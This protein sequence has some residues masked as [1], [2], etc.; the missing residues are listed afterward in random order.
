MTHSLSVKTEEE[1]NAWSCGQT[2][3][4]H[5][6]EPS[7]GGLGGPWLPLTT[8]ARMYHSAVK[9]A[10][11]CP[12]RLLVKLQRDMEELW[13]LAKARASHGKGEG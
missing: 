12:D 5:L 6:C 3:L 9:D 11:V 7:P 4:A 8:D 13:V 2:L 10:M 1:R